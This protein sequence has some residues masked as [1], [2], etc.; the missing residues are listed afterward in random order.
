MKMIA[1]CASGRSVQSPPGT[2]SHPVPAVSRSIATRALLKPRSDPSPQVPAFT[3][4]HCGVPLR[5]TSMSVVNGQSRRRPGP[6]APTHV[7]VP[8]GGRWRS[9]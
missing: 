8:L 7:S 2:G 6:G 5:K 4:A 9:V 3:Y 1:S